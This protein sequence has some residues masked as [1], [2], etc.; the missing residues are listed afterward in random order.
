TAEQRAKL[1]AA[2]KG[3]T[4]GANALARVLG[5]PFFVPRPSPVRTPN[6]LAFL[7]GPADAEAGRRVFEHPKLAGCFKCHQVEGRGANVGPDLSLIGRTERRW[8]LESILQPSAVVAPHYQAWTILTTDE[9]T[10]TGL[11]VHTQLDESTYVDEKGNRFKV[12][13]GQ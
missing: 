4:D 7:E 11:L 2:V 5:Q 13:A 12:L 1:E 6:W 8:I 10:L 9:R 3:N